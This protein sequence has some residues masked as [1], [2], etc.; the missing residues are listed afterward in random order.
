[1]A[2]K[3]SVNP[4][5]DW[6]YFSGGDTCAFDL[7]GDGKCHGDEAPEGAQP[8]SEKAASAQ[9]DGDPGGESE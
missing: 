6:C 4:L 2:V 1:M 5:G 9:G 7:L 8:V 3:C